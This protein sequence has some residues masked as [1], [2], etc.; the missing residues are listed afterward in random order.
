[1]KKPALKHLVIAVIFVVIPAVLAT[2]TIYRKLT[3]RSRLRR[4]ETL[5]HD[6]AEEA[7][8][9]GAALTQVLSMDLP[10]DAVVLLYTGATRAQLEP[11]GCYVGQSGGVEQRAAAVEHM[12][13]AGWEPVVVDAGAFSGGSAAPDRLRAEA[14]TSAMKAIGYSGV[15]VTRDDADGFAQGLPT[16]DAGGGHGAG[17]LLVES[18]GQRVAIVGGSS[19][20][21]AG[22]IRGELAAS[23][24]PDMVVL[25]TDATAAGVE[26]LVEQVDG[27]D[28]V[29]SSTAAADSTAGGVMVLSCVPDGELLGFA[30]VR[31]GASL[32]VVARH[33][34]LLTDAAGGHAGVAEIVAAFYATME[35]DVSGAVGSVVSPLAGYASEVSEGAYVGS[36]ACQSCHVAEHEQWKA[37]A[38]GRAFHTLRAAKRDYVPECVSCHVAGYGLDT[39]YRIAKPVEAL[40]GVGCETCHGPGKQ[41]VLDPAPENIRGEVGADV[42]MSCHDPQHSPGFDRLVHDAM[43]DVDHSRPPVDLRRLLDDRV[44]EGARPDVDLFVMSFCPWGTRAEKK[45]LPLLRDYADDV[46]FNIHFIVSDK[47]EEAG[48]AP[49]VELLEQPSEETPEDPFA[50]YTALHGE[51][52]LV[53]NFRQVLIQQMYADVF[54]DYVL[55]RADHQEDPWRKGAERFGIDPNRVTARMQ[56]DEG[57]RSFLTNVARSRALNA[58]ASPTLAVDGYIYTA[59]VYTPGNDVCGAR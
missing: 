27:V 5:R 18:R 58:R 15:A 56:T 24:D 33:D 9:R 52:E 48:N 32:E 36:D 45:V 8:Q 41:H 47:P 28:V 4:L 44:A 49:D 35:S 13:D 20:E 46:D 29:I 59:S 43:A 25:L 42:C 23:Q 16:V 19:V 17:A 10:N 37:T 54:F 6:V 12:R 40:Q 22:R 34:V 14:Y 26:P 38:H 31:P 11:C 57:R 2:P 50:L 51:R 39:G 30:A 3:E 53:E 7:T 55:W 21:D 1:M